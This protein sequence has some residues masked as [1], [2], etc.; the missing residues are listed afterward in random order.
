MNKFYLLVF[1]LM[2]SAS[3]FAQ[4]NFNTETKYFPGEV[5]VQTKQGYSIS[6]IANSF[7]PSYEIE[8]MEELST[9]MRIWHLKFNDNVISQESFLRKIMAHP[10]VRIAQNNHYIE[11]RATMPNDP[12]VAANQWHHNNTGQTGGTV[13]AD[14]DS[15]EAWDITTGGLTIQGDTIVV[16]IVE[17]GGANYNHTDLIN[18]FW[19]NYGEIPNNS[20]DDDNNGY[21]DDYEGWNVNGN[22]DNHSAGN[23]GT[24]CMGMVGAKGNNGVGVVG[25]NWNVKMMLVSGFST[26]ESSVIAAY[27]YP[28]KMRKMYNESN[29][30]EGAFVVATSASWGID[31]ADPNN[32]PLWCAFYD[33]LGTYGILNPG[34]T[35]NSNFNVDVVGDMP[36]ACASDY[37]VS[38]TRTNATDGQAGGYGATTIDFGAPGIDVY[39]TSGSSSYGTT[40]GTSFSCP[41][42]AGVIGLLY[43][44]PCNSLITLA[45]SNPQAAADEVLLALMQGVDLV[46][47]MSGISV[48]GGRLNAFNSVNLILGNCSASSC[49]TPYNLNTTGL[50]DTEVTLNWTNGGASTDFI[51]YF[52]ESGSLIWDSLSVSSSSLFIDTLTGCSDYEFMVRAICPPTDTSGY[53]TIYSFSTDGCCN[54][55]T[56]VTLSNITN[57]EITIDFGS[58]LAANSY[59]IYYKPLSDSVWMTQSSLTNSVMIS[60][61]DS[62]TSYE[63]NVQTI[64]TGDSSNTTT[65]LFFNTSGCGLCESSAYCTAS[66]NDSS[67]EWLNNVTVNTINY[68]SGNNSGYDYSGL[69]TELFV[70]QTYNISMSPGFS[71]STYSE[72]FVAWIDYDGNGVLD[73]TTEEIYNSGTG[74]TTAVNGNFT[75]PNGAFE[76]ITRLRVAMKYVG[77]TGT[78]PLPC[79]MFGYG[80]VEDYCVEIIDTT[81]TNSIE[82]NEEGSVIYMIYPNPANEYFTLE[83]INYKELSGNKFIELYNSVGQLVETKPITSKTTQLNLENLASGIYYYSIHLD[84]MRRTGKVIINK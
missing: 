15:D 58:V 4:I 19:R 68:T 20:I 8:I 6:Q 46:P 59:N 27:S 16:C 37:M 64:C 7:S 39:T 26:A 79:G 76:G 9:H 63:I 29:G 5:L 35:T 1:T 84:N 56:G 42:T 25:A 44:V 74:V 49:I 45:K 54:A 31:Q 40:T 21:V 65:S 77:G 81:S 43:S 11:E 53:S 70:G 41:L 24:Q 2:M 33:T 83:I 10:G 50:T 13:D 66:G 30:T 69:V 61:L 62:C 52:R 47:S 72:H 48:T 22:N 57:D 73:A 51:F 17:G 55:P 80:E 18:N 75:V 28:L 12:N 3:S 82:T 36:T 38:V 14:I 32:Y 67:D 71:G 34:A 60:G 78:A 23:H